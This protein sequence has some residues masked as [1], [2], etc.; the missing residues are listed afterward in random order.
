MESADTDW[1]PAI[2]VPYEKVIADLQREQVA[3]ANIDQAAF[4]SANNDAVADLAAAGRAWDAAHC[5]VDDVFAESPQPQRVRTSRQSGKAMCTSRGAGAPAP[6]ST[7][8]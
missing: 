7:S 1:P 5:K 8:A 4:M 3:C 2:K 6:V